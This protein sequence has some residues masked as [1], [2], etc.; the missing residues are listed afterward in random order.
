MTQSNSKKTMKNLWILPR[1][2]LQTR[3]VQK[4][5]IKRKRNEEIE[6]IEKM[7]TSI[8]IE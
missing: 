4:Q 5:K 3:K 1:S 8:K 7:I 2:I 6:E